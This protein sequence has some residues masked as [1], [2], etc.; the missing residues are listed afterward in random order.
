ML[1]SYRVLDL[2]D[3]RGAMAGF[4]LAAL[5]ADVIAVEPPGGSTIRCQRLR[6]ILG[7]SDDRIAEL[8]AAGALE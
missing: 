6:D 7:Y 3:E 8:V 5:G 1:S 4:I 2:T